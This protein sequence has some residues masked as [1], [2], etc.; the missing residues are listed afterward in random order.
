MRP[1]PQPL[2]PLQYEELVRRSLVEDLGAA[3][4]RTG[5]ALLAPGEV[6]AGRIRMRRPA[7]VCGL[8]VAL[9]AFR[10]L[11]PALE[12]EIALAEG[13]DAEAGAEIAALRGSARALLAAERTALN[14]LGHLSGVATATRDLVRRVA[15]TR[16]RIVGT[17]KTLPGLGALQKY[18]IRVGGGA[19]HRFGLYDAVLIKDN[20]LALCGGVAEAVRRARRSAGHMVKLEIE[21]ETLEQLDEALAVGVDAVLLDNMPPALLRR[22]VERVGGCALTEASG[23]IT[24]DNVAEVAA[25]GVDVISVGWLTHGAPAVDVGFDLD[26]IR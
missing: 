18:A 20:H 9:C 14:L 22:A 15:G 13:A 8:E 17:R 26:P 2:H 3:G 10:Q 16:A 7:R 12:A 25:A 19:N 23:G 4:D 11:D 24:P 5:D 6:A 1:A 21:V